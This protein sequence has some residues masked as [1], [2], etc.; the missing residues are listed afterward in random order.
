M[1]NERFEDTKAR[2]QTRIGIKGK[3][4]EKIKF[5]VV[6]KLSYSKPQYLGDGMYPQPRIFFC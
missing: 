3:P 6:K 2:L 1:Q 5:A 4:F